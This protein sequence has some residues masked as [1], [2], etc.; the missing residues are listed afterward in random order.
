MTFV[1][2]INA[3]SLTSVPSEV[4]NCA[5]A[6]HHETTCTAKSQPCVFATFQI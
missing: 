1:T 4:C 5:S 2:I 3:M 6:Q